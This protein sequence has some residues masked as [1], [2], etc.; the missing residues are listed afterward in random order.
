MKVSLIYL[1]LEAR[2]IWESTSYRGYVEEILDRTT[3][4]FSTSLSSF[5]D[6]MSKMQSGWAR[7]PYN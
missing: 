3:V 7:I 1:L 6:G 2:D 5:G 4:Y